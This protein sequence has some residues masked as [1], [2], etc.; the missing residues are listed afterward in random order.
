MNYTLQSLDVI[1]L[2]FSDNGLI[3]L[4]I[5][6][7]V[8]M[9]GIALELKIEHF[10]EL[11][12]RP[13]P[14]IVGLISQLIVLP[15]ITLVAVVLLHKFLTPTIALG[16]ILVAACPGGNISN[17]FNSVAKSNVALAISLTGV[18]TVLA[19]ITTPFNFAFYGN[20]YTHYIATHIATNLVRPLEI[21]IWQM[22]RT[23]VVILGIPLVLGIGIS[24]KFP[25]FTK[26][27]LKPAK[28]I[29][30]I[31]LSLIIIGA[32]S[33][34]MGYFIK[35]AP[36]V[37][38]LVIAHNGLAYLA[39]YGFAKVVGMTKFNCR[40]ISI[41]TGIHNSGL[42]LVLLFNEKIFPADL[43]IGGM[44][45]IAAGWGVWDIISGGILAAYWKR[46]PIE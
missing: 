14:A 10:Q 42:A 19:I 5:S 35:Y 45:F 39:G 4:N 22:F 2:N 12:K 38:G 3:L 33:G 1:R 46:K 37:F 23:V 20:I 9:F 24:N 34:N 44:A 8:I 36:L 16:M 27:I 13:K 26:K 29:S 7:A 43:A 28:T 17:Y 18:S 40:T 30:L 21:D 41:E 6:L 32:I 25:E 31:L 15:V 11:I